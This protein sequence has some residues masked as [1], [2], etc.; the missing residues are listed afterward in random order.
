MGSSLAMPGPVPAAWMSARG[1]DKDTI[2]ATILAM[3]VVAYTVALLLQFALAGISTDSLRLTAKLVPSTIAGILVG[4]Y[5]SSRISDPTF[6]WLLTIIL[7]FTT[8]I[9]F[10]TLD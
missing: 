9:L 4:R 8:I 2:R 7:A 5:L 6:R 10:A 3:F 1:F